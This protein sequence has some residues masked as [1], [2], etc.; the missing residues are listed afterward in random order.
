MKSFSSFHSNA[1]LDPQIFVANVQKLCLDLAKHLF[2]N[3][4]PEVI[5]AREVHSLWMGF[6]KNRD[7]LAANYMDKE[8]SRLAY[9]AGFLLPNI[10][11]VFGILCK[12]EG[13]IHAS[14]LKGTNEIHLLDFGSGPLSASVGFL[15]WLGNQKL[16]VPIKKIKI[17]AVDRNKEVVL[18]G[19]SLLEPSKRFPKI[20]VEFHNNLDKIEKNKFDLIFSVNA[21][22]EIPLDKRLK[23]LKS[24]LA[25]RAPGGVIVYVEPGQD[26]H[27]RELGF[28]RDR[29]LESMM[30]GNSPTTVLAPCFHDKPCPLSLHSNR[31]DWCWFSDPWED[32]P[33]AIS[34]LDR[35]CGFDHKSLSYSFLLI[36]KKVSGFKAHRVLSDVI[37]LEPNGNDHTKFEKIKSYM[38]RNLPPNLDP[39]LLQI[40]SGAGFFEKQILCT[41]SGALKS[42]WFVPGFSKSPLQKLRGDFVNQSDFTLNHWLVLPEQNKLVDLK[43]SFVESGLKKIKKKRTL[44]DKMAATS[45]PAKSTLSKK[46]K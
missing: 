15:F 34:L 11:K 25:A 9:L 43:E 21:L 45:K 37:R 39:S 18:R 10:Q 17:V 44:K 33:Q 31:P 8:P 19:I 2:P 38:I 26:V 3:D 30:Q 29:L 5:L 36:G 1:I 41:A 35:W 14:L 22:N 40:I 32:I 27:S 20:E 24:L 13:R 7:K 4:T 42:L 23:I 28:V 16:S 46:K 12:Q 6:N